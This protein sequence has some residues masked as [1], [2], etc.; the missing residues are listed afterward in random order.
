MVDR[1]GRCSQGGKQ[2]TTHRRKQNVRRCTAISSAIA[3]SLGAIGISAPA[4]AGGTIRASWHLDGEG[5]K[6]G[7]TKVYHPKES[8]KGSIGSYA[9]DLTSTHRL[10]KG[11]GSTV[12]LLDTGI[13]TSNGNFNPA[14]SRE[15]LDKGGVDRTGSNNPWADNDGHGTA[16]ASIIVGQASKTRPIRG[17]APEAKV[18]PVKIID[19]QPDDSADPNAKMA[20]KKAT[21]ERLIQGINWAADNAGVDIIALPLIVDADNQQLKDAVAKA[22]AKGKVV[23]AAAGNAENK[24][25][26]SDG[27]S[28]GS[29]SSRSAESST[30]SSEG[31]KGA[32]ANI[33]YPAGYPGVIGVTASDAKGNVDESVIHSEAVQLVAPGQNMI[34]ANGSTGICLTSTQAPSTSYATAYVAGVA[35]LVKSRHPK[36]SG[37][38]ITYRLLSSANRGSAPGWT[39]ER[40]WGFVDPYGAV[41]MVD[42]GQIPGPTSPVIQRLK[43]VPTIGSKVPPPEHDPQ[44]IGRKAGMIWA[45]AGVGL[46]VVLLI[47]AAGRS[48]TAL[49]KSDDSSAEETE[50]T[51]EE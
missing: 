45:G 32:K 36:E 42:D 23:V 19:S 1:S 3:I 10:T 20:Q 21:L 39:K 24:E 34:V 49:R 14:I 35:A 29:S 47:V 13:A 25:D 38:M 48:R 26:D 12:A 40:G 30:S 27:S 43:P 5:C 9:I 31:S 6:Q 17:V 7:S 44:G 37:A 18:I 33:R 41:T 28:S 11:K 50:E 46:I 2:V 22:I 8:E 15:K 16:T 51:E 4:N